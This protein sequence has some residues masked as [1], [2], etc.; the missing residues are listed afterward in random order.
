MRKVLLFSLLLSAFG[1]QRSFAQTCNGSLTVVVEGSTTNAPLD[2]TSTDTQ[3]AC[4]DADGALTGAID[5]EVTGGSPGYTYQ[6]TKDGTNFSTDQDLTGLGSGSYQVV[7]TDTKNCTFVYGPIVITEP[8][9]IAVTESLTDLSCNATD[10]TAD[11]AI[12]LTV[13]GGTGGYTYTWSTA[14]GSG[15]S[16]GAQD[17][18]GLSAGTYD[19]T[20]TDA[21]AC[22]T[23][24]SYTLTQPTSIAIVETLTDLSCNA[25]SGAA[26]G[27]ISLAVSGGTGSYT[28]SWSTTDGS[29]LSASAQNQSGLSA[30][31]YDVTVTDANNCTS[32]A[33]YTLSQPTDIVATA[34]SPEQGA[35]DPDNGNVTYNIL[36][37]GG[38]GTIDISATGG[39][40]SYTYNLDGGTF[41]ASSTFTVGAGTYTLI[42]KD[43]NGCTSDPITVTVTEPD[44][45]L[46][47][48]CTVAQ[49]QCQV[50]TGEIKIEA[51][52][53]VAPYNV[54]YTTNVPANTLDQASGQTIGNS[55]GTTTFTGADGNTTYSFTVTDANG[56]AVN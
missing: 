15:L 3:P 8:T 21:N 46:A 56:C 25:A 48:S 53:G 4:N 19:V 47:G 26:D 35:S 54:T 51:V 50:G 20:I 55:G 32:T 11:G 28:F 34:F 5:L 18:T 45:L 24:R 9:A 44:Q 41:Q 13:S 6:W 43:A 10:G 23:N 33:S 7:I 27:A 42:A 31:T 29:G 37:N 17:Q 49:D 30:G 22:T 16:A 40:G 39:T 12:D 1:L 36:C 52:D 38:D 14:D 2:A